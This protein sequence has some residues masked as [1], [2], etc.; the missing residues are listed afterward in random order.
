M[1][2]AFPSVR[3]SRFWRAL[4]FAALA[5]LLV[6]AA[7]ADVPPIGMRTPDYELTIEN[8]AS[9]PNHVFFV[10]PTTNSG[11][12]YRLESGKGLTSLMMRELHGETTELFV[13]TRAAFDKSAK[14]HSYPH[15]D[16]GAVVQVFKPISGALKSNV[17][18]APPAFQPDTSNVSKIERVLR[19]SRLDND[20]FELSIVRNDAV[21]SN[22]SRMAVA[23]DAPV[24]ATP[25]AS[26]AR[27]TLSAPATSHS[28]APPTR[29]TGCGCNLG[30]ADDGDRSVPWLAAIALALAARAIYSVRTRSA[31]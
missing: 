26:P 22:G 6:S 23:L 17:A 9:Y 3:D 10:Y 11:Y 4:R 1:L 31:R 30:Q 18:I 29:R 2:I 20:A 16:K 14:A 12:A 25:A 15:G 24:T 19:I 7:H 21:L 27:P 5:I 13:T 8:L 28:S